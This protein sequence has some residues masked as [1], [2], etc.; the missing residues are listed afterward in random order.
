MAPSV[1]IAVVSWNTRD[2]LRRCLRSLAA[3]VDAGR[4]EVWVVDNGSRDG[5]AAM[6]GNEF[7]WAKLLAQD[8]NVGFG[9]A[10]NLVAERTDT[11]W[12][13]CANAD[14]ELTPGALEQLLEAGV[15]D[16]RAGI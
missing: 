10:V 2:L 14:T 9:A 15:R 1:A 6:V 13:A 11:P 16:P 12:I 3:E 4:A 8:S 5:S 7:G